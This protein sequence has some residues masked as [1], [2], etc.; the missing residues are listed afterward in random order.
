MAATRG[1]AHDRAIRLTACAVLRR[2][3]PALRLLTW[4]VWFGGHM[5]DE[6]QA[7]LL[8][9][10]DRRR[11]DVIALQEVTPELHAR[12]RATAALADAYELS[13]P[14]G[15]SLRDYGVLLLARGGLGRIEQVT[16]PSSM[17]RRL[18]VAEL[19]GGLT[20]ATV[21]LES[22]GDC[23][24]ERVAQLGL[25]QA[26]LDA[27]GDDVVLCGDFNFT[28]TDAA[29]TAALDPRWVDVWPA[30]RGGEPGYTVD[31]DVNTMR[32]QVKQKP[33]YKRID[34]VLLRG[35][36]WQARSIELVGTVPFDDEGTFVSDHFGLEA[37]LV[38]PASGR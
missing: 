30:L 15:D 1:G 35:A 20:V 12:L 7:A 3:V 37:T 26:Y 14:D 24:A 8:D 23:V 5:L 13:D 31:T 32:Y 9:E 2:R 16:L 11:P 19:P 27:A 33:T 29:E 17:G 10:L 25:I 4:N 22:T 18:L 34:R 28:P 38:A 21:H 6:R 36:R